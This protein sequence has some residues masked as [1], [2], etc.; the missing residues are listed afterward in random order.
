M[1]R[2]SFA[3]KLPVHCIVRLAALSC[4]VVQVLP[5]ISFGSTG[6]AGWQCPLA[7][8]HLNY[9]WVLIAHAHVDRALVF[10][11]VTHVVERCN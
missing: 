8:F 5:S 10:W 11:M 1:P 7:F 2:V 3:P 6:G 9:L 4:K